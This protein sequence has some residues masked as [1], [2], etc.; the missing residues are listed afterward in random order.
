MTLEEFIKKYDGKTVGYPEGSYVG[1]CLSL[2]K[3][4]IKECFGINPPPSGSN[5]AYGY[6]SNFPSPLGDVFEKVANTPTGVP[7][8]GDIIIWNTNTG[9]G[10]GHIAVFLE[11]DTNRFTSFDQ[12]YYGR[13]AH[14]QNHNYTNVVG[15]L[16]PKKDTQKDFQW[17][18]QMFIEYNAVDVYKPEGEIRGK[19]QEVFDGFKKYNE[20]TK[21]VESLE[22][23]LAGA[24]G[25]AA[26]NEERLRISE[27]SLSEVRKEIDELEEKVSRRD[28]E[29][30]ELLDKINRL[31]EAIDPDTKIIISKE[32][33]ERLQ[34]RRNADRLTNKEIYEEAIRRFLSHFSP[35]SI[36]ELWNKDKEDMKGGGK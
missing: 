28:T 30:S 34:K 2:V 18:R 12:N 8:A 24:K 35:A 10:Y 7:N 31:Q 26:E 9:G 25:E 13:H 21:K 14:K 11:G 15:W 1:E 29:I 33:Y 27:R 22:K 4:Y 20:L 23:D 16:K 32:E 36:M 3:W 5:S 19:V 6:W 17:L